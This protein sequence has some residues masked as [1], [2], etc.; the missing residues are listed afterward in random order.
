MSF[1][2][3]LIF[4]EPPDP[5]PGMQAT[6]AAS[7]KVGL[8]QVELGR[9]QLEYQK[10]RAEKT[11]ALTADLIKS[12]M[13]LM[14]T[15]RGV[16]QS[17]YDRYQKTYAPIEDRIAKDALGFDTDAEKER[18][19]SLARGDIAQGF[20]GAQ[21]QALRSQARFGLRPNANALAAINSQ[22]SA[23]QAGQTASAM[24]NARYAAR[25]AGDQRRMNAVNIGKGL[26]GTAATAASGSVNAGNAAGGLQFG[27]N[28]SY[29]AG[30]ASANQFTNSGVNALGQAGNIYGAISNYGL[31][32]YDMQAQQTAALI[33][34]GAMFFAADGTPGGTDEP[35]LD[36]DG[37]GRVRGPGTTTSDS[38]P[39]MLSKGEYVIPA[40]VVQKKGVEFFDKLLD[41]YHTPAAIQEQRKY[42]IRRK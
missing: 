22:L 38:I 5:N 12:Q 9:E 23:Q 13:G 41:R 21:Q 39:A 7:E 24:T 3:D 29:N 11:D 37:K 17:E 18:Y 31:K 16:A 19:A 25:D 1:V 6:A 10:A 28:N 32:S 8:A 35:A 36:Q 42:G 27:A 40:D 34:A 4:G 33:N 15:Q 30:M 20:R 2:R 14:D 26:P